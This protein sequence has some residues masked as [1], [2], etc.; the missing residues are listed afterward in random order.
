MEQVLLTGVAP[1]KEVEDGEGGG[2]DEGDKLMSLAVVVLAATAAAVAPEMFGYGL[3]PT[4]CSPHQGVASP[5]W[6]ALP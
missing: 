5:C 1:C 2:D 3:K 6:T 4:K